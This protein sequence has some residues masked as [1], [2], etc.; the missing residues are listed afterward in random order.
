MY[1]EFQSLSAC[2]KS[3]VLCKQRKKSAFHTQDSLQSSLKN[4][5]YGK[6]TFFPHLSILSIVLNKIISL[7][8]YPNNYL[9]FAD[10]FSDA[11]KKTK[12]TGKFPTIK[13]TAYFSYQ[14]ADK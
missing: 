1:F 11:L 4:P 13:R 10:L 2:G 3:T 5:M 6:Q 8:Q 7:E 14:Q 9:A 12:K